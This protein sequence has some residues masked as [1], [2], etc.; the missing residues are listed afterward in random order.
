VGDLDEA[1][2]EA[3]RQ[4]ALLALVVETSLVLGADLEL[5]T[6]LAKLMALAERMLGAEASS[7]MLLGEGRAT[8]HWAVAGG[9][10][11]TD[12]LGQTTLAMGEGIA[13]IVAATGEAIIVADAEH[14]ARVARRVD[15][16]TGFHT[17]SIVCVPIRF[18][19]TVTGVIQ[20]LNKRVGTFDQQD[21]EILALI[22]AEAGVAI[23][24]TRVYGTLEERVR[25]RPP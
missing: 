15:A 2:D 10:V 9:P 17:R 20:V 3:A 19:G 8:L 24:N 13:G 16:A 6:L 11:P 1:R 23:E 4:R 22:A 5:S 18:R 21:G 7:V 14:D 25:E 12:V